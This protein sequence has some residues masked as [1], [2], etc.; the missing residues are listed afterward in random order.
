MKRLIFLLILAFLLLSPVCHIAFDAAS[1]SVYMVANGATE[2]QVVCEL[3]M[4]VDNLD[5]VTSWGLSQTEYYEYY[6]C[7]RPVDFYF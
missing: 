5:R 6:N 1:M 4:Y 2:K 3:G 7:N